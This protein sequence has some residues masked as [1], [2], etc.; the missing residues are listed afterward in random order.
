VGGV[1]AVEI[2]RKRS[3]VAL[4][5]GLDVSDVLLRREPNLLGRQHDW[6]AVGVIG[7]HKM[8]GA[9]RHP[10]RAH[11]DVAVDIADQMTKM[12]LAV[13]VGQ[14]AGDQERSRRH[15]VRND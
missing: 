1:V 9:P 10:L 2:D 15:C 7:A 6:R 12:Q 4:V 11:P 8:R 5:R 3:K 13:S 14:G